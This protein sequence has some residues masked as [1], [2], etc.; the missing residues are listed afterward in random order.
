MLTSVGR[1]VASSEEFPTCVAAGSPAV[2]CAVGEDPPA[3]RRLH[4]IRSQHL[5]TS[6]AGHSIHLVQHRTRI[7]FCGITRPEDAAAAARAGADAIGLVFYEP[8]ARHVTPLV[9]EKILSELPPFVTPVG[10][11]ADAPTEDILEIADALR[12]RHIQLNGHETPERVAELRGFS[13][14]KAIR[15]SADS[16]VM[17]LAKWRESIRGQRLSNLHG[18]VLETAGTSQPGGTGV[19]N[20]FAAIEAARN[21]GAFEGLPPLIAAGGLTPENVAHVVRALKPWAVD[22][23]SGIEIE[24]GKKSLERMQQFANAV[25]AVQEQ[26]A[27]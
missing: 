24:K 7:K 6:R 17:E 1:S 23:S 19:V 20:D 3:S 4:A 26:H 16:L 21:A 25:R 8:V 15:V 27:T 14:I 5:R 9:A 2:F 18:I 10:L 12:I 13:V 22:V 11:F